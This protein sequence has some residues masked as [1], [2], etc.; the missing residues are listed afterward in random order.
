VVERL[1]LELSLDDE[2]WDE[3]VFTKNRDLIDGDIA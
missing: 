2:I 3:T 1:R